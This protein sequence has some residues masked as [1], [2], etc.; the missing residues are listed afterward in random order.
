M[1]TTHVQGFT[2]VELLIVIVV[3]AILAAITVISY[4]GMVSRANEARLGSD[5]SDIQKLTEVF[6]INNAHYPRSSDST[7]WQA[8]ANSLTAQGI[9][10]PYDNGKTSGR[11]GTSSFCN[12]EPNYFGN[13]TY[14]SG[15]EYLYFTK[16]QGIS[17]TG[18]YGSGCSITASQ[19]DGYV[20]MWY[21][22]PTNMIRFHTDNPSSFTISV[23]GTSSVY[24]NQQCVFS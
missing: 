11:L 4:N 17:N 2:I 23:S 22:R 21:D 7:E 10:S 8:F 5:M 16:N 18:Q 24:P 6:N 12:S 15:Y 20:L 3:I 14:C 1:K 19:G 13:N 9:K